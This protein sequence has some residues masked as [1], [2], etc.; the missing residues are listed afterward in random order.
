MNFPGLSALATSPLRLTPVSSQEQL[1]FWVQVAA[2]L[3]LA[4]TLGRL[5]SRLGQPPVVGQLL[6]GV[7]LG[8]TVFGAVWRSGFAWFL[9]SG[10]LVQSSLLLAISTLSLAVLLLTAGFETDI[11]L[12]RRLGRPASWVTVGSLLIPVGA[13]VLVGLALP[14]SLRGPSGGALSFALLVGVALGASSLPVIAEIVGHLGATR[15]DFGQITLA[16]GTVNDAGAFLLIALAVALAGQGALSQLARLVI[17]LLV[18]GGLVYVFGQTIIDRLLRLARRSGP[19]HGAPNTHPSLAISLAVAMVAAALVQLVGIEGALGSFVAGVVLARSRFGDAETFRFLA[20]MSSVFFAPLYFASAGLE[21]NLILLRQP[22]TALVFGCLVIVGTTTKFFGSYLGAALGGLPRLE[23]VALGVGLNGRG[24]VQVIAGTV[25][26]GAGI[27]GGG[28]Y[29]AIVAMALLT[30]LATPPLLRRV[31]R[32]WEGSPAERDRLD[33]E[34]R[35]ASHLMVRPERVLLVSDNE[36]AGSDALFLADRAWPSDAPF[37]VVTCGAVT[38]LAQGSFD[39]GDARTIDGQ[40][41]A[42]SEIVAAVRSE[43]KLGCA[44][45]IIGTHLDQTGPDG[46]STLLQELL[47][48]AQLP[49]MIVLRGSGPADPRVL[50]T[51]RQILVAMSAGRASRASMEFGYSLAERTGAK[52]RL[53]RIDTTPRGWRSL[54]LDRLI[55]RRIG[56]RGQRSAEETALEQAIAQAES[57][58]VTATAELQSHSQYARGVANAAAGDDLIVLGVHPVATADGTYLGPAAEMLL[59]IAPNRSV[60]IAIPDGGTSVRSGSRR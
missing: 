42:R 52:V 38:P 15:R 6:A 60:F 45:L 27:I 37:T 58:H 17:G 25:G 9:P 30:S 49:L 21:A 14:V 47:P 41:V 18:L 40:T 46:P 48:V 56:P 28:T 10:D 2:L 29:T 55:S 54:R 5:A 31:V 16:A 7:I 1:V 12:L 24:T 36:V 59:E 33:R 43:L 39:K 13:G 11:T 44:A 26:L 50:V 4:I 32:R 35:W 3:S 34:A 51:L 57:Y 19:D 8:P 20:Q 53:L 22:E 23:R